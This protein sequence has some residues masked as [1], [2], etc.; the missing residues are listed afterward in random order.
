[1][2]DYLNHYF[3]LDNHLVESNFP[4]NKKYFNTDIFY[5]YS[6]MLEL[7]LSIDDF[8]LTHKKKFWYNIKRSSRLFEK[9]YGETYFETHKN[10]E[11]FNSLDP[12]R[13]IFLKRWSTSYTSFFWKRD[14]G[15]KKFKEFINRIIIDYPDSFQISLLKI[16][17]S[18]EIIAYSIGFEL[19]NCYHFWMHSVN[20][21]YSLSKFSV[22]TVFLNNLISHLII[23]GN[24][25]NFDF[26]LGLNDYKLKWAKQ[27]KNIYWRVKTNRSIFNIPKHIFIVLFYFIKIRIQKNKYLSNHIKKIFVS[28]ERQKKLGSIFKI[29]EQYVFKM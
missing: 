7:P 15:Y 16:K 22:G 8:K 23:E 24:I 9:D 4:K 27:K 29:L 6:P 20:I 14:L 28:L 25:K 1:M 10:K 2:L 5:D 19:N 13:E 26:M 12:V 3:K 11:A 21:K 18:N 17:S